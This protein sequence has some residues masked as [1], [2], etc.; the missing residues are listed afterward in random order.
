[1]LLKLVVGVKDFHNQKPKNW[2]IYSK[3]VGL[4]YKT[5]FQPLDNVLIL[6]GAQIEGANA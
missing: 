2:P 1:M 6:F 5:H 3:S 4:G